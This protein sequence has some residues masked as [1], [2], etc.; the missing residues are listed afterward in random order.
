[1]EKEILAQT[2]RNLRMK[3]EFHLLL[4]H[5][6]YFDVNNFDS[7]FTFIFVATSISLGVHFCNSLYFFENIPSLR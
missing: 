4:Y 6:S 1:M 5:T 3:K 7:K 2:N